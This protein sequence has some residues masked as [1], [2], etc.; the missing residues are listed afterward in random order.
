MTGS[1]AISM[2][3]PAGPTVTLPPSPPAAVTDETMGS[4][5]QQPDPIPSNEAQL[6]PSPTSPL[7]NPTT[8]SPEDTSAAEEKP[9]VMVGTTSSTATSPAQPTHSLL[10]SNLLSAAFNAASV[11]PVIGPLADS[12]QQ[13]LTAS[14]LSPSS[15]STSTESGSSNPTP[16]ATTNT[17]SAPQPAP[18]ADQPSN[19]TD[20]SATPVPPTAGAPTSGAV[21]IIAQRRPSGFLATLRSTTSTPAPPPSGPVAAGLAAFL[22]ASFVPS[23]P[24]AGR[25]FPRNNSGSGSTA[26]NRSVSPNAK[27][28]GTRPRL[29]PPMTLSGMGSATTSNGSSPALSPAPSSPSSPV[30]P[31]TGPVAGMGGVQPAPPATGARRLKPPSGM[32]FSSLQAPAA[33]TATMMPTTAPPQLR[34][35]VPAPPVQP[36]PP[37]LSQL[38]PHPPPATTAEAARTAFQLIEITSDYLAD[39]IRRSRGLPE[40]ATAMSGGSTAVASATATVAPSPSLVPAA[41]ASGGSVPLSQAST[42]LPSRRGSIGG[43]PD[44]VSGDDAGGASGPATALNTPPT[45]S[46]E[47]EDE[48]ADGG[49]A[50]RRKIPSP[51]LTG[52]GGLAASVAPA[53][54][55]GK[56]TPT[57]LLLDVRSLMAYAQ[58]TVSSAVNLYVPATLLRKAGLAAPTL[59]PAAAEDGAK[60]AAVSAT[61][62]AVEAGR[63]AAAEGDGAA[64]TEMI[65]HIVLYDADSEGVQEGSALALLAERL[66]SGAGVAPPPTTEGLVPS[67]AAGARLAPVAE[68]AAAATPAAAASA[69]VA[70]APANH[71]GAVAHLVQALGGLLSERTTMGWLK[72]GVKAFVEKHADLCEV[73][74][75]DGRA[76]GAAPP[77]AAPAGSGARRDEETEPVAAKPEE[78]GSVVAVTGGKPPAAGGGIGGGV[79]FLV[80]ASGSVIT[81]LLSTSAPFLSSATLG[82][83]PLSSGGGWGGSATASSANPAAS[84]ASRPIPAP[85]TL[86]APLLTPGIGAGPTGGRDGAPSFFFHTPAAAASAAGSYFGASAAAASGYGFGGGPTTPAAVPLLESP[87]ASARYVQPVSPPDLFNLDVLRSC[88]PSPSLHHEEMAG[89]SAGNGG[90]ATPGPES[91]GECRAPVGTPEFLRGVIEGGDARG[92]LMG[93]WQVLEVDERRRLEVASRARGPDDWF[94][95]SEGLEGGMRNRYSN[96]WPFNANR[97]RLNHPPYTTNS[98]LASQDPAVVGTGPGAPMDYINAS[99][100]MPP[101]ASEA[102]VSALPLASAEAGADEIRRRAK[103]HARRRRY[104]ATQGPVPA[105]FDEFWRMVWEQES[106]VIVMLCESDARGRKCHTYY[107]TVPLN[108]SASHPIST[109]ESSQPFFPTQS[110]A[111]ATHTLRYGRMEVTLLA[112]RRVR[113]LI[114]LR[115]FQLTLH[116]APG[117]DETAPKQTRVVAQIQYVGWPD[118]GVPESPDSVLALHHLVDRVAEAVE[119]GRVP[120]DEDVEG[121]TRADGCER[122]PR[123]HPIV[124][125]CSAGCGRTGA[126]VA[127][128]ALLAVLYP[129]TYPPLYAG[130]SSTSGSNTVSTGTSVHAA[131]REIHAMAMSSAAQTSPMPVSVGDGVPRHRP[132]SMSTASLSSIT[133]QALM[134]FPMLHGKGSGALGE[135]MALALG[136]GPSLAFQAAK[137]RD[138]VLLAVDHLRSQRIS[139]VQ[140]L[141]QFLFLY[142]VLL[143]RVKHQ[144]AAASG[145]GTATNAEDP[146]ANHYAR[147][148]IKPRR[149]AAAAREVRA[150]ITAIEEEGLSPEEAVSEVRRRSA[151]SS[152][153]TPSTPQQPSGLSFSSSRTRRRQQASDSCGQECGWPSSTSLTGTLSGDE[154]GAPAAHGVQRKASTSAAGLRRH[155]SGRRSG[156]AGTG[157]ALGP[158]APRTLQKQLTSSREELGRF[159]AAGAV[160]SCT[161]GSTPFGTATASAQVAGGV[162]GAVGSQSS[163]WMDLFPLEPETPGS[164]QVTV[165]AWGLDD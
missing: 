17:A 159:A 114:H 36:Q 134:V 140:T 32:L 156:A 53:T 27:P 99:H 84:A 150:F 136:T 3:G 71:A 41:L 165:T 77:T 111:T 103:N 100:I 55:E 78:A 120:T 161:L 16:D 131:K 70:P 123:S 106:R 126:F 52:K 144:A 46:S 49:G 82:M 11:L 54:T 9:M 87:G 110:A 149:T 31:P 132:R 18:A 51:T 33:A 37:Q 15:S 48:D 146:S 142:E 39:L 148:V 19:T 56:R 20:T 130:A 105:T 79:G 121:E 45:S 62:A 7:T 5:K 109:P 124:V 4:P 42:A 66:A 90:D 127:M 112:S 85:V 154:G 61:P 96:I 76:G 145:A 57:V 155:P 93:K 141:P 151:R 118:A 14:P 58:A 129:D 157:N 125:H 44:A 83:F 72:G 101:T 137:G 47:E 24:V 95:V 128:D 69:A 138:A 98:A 40:A 158:G 22:P 89:G 23:G 81:H 26:A 102:F 30:V 139:M 88:S 160:A 34:H 1:V 38:L 60:E 113:S 91:G 153:S 35:P 75:I 8:I 59:A 6:P 80:S 122:D 116:P 21:P 107:P 64:A 162:A 133:Q 2:P 147:L 12:L 13:H 28:A 97:I 119:D 115:T 94:C 92:E 10:H 143:A 108:S 163:G 43:H 73:V 68:E 86:Q 63:P 152:A 104:I 117:S 135:D 65:D 50:K 67:A 25:L 164:A 29:V 74:G